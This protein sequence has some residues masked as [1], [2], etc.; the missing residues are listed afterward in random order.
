M[1][2]MKYGRT[3]KTSTPPDKSNGNES[4]KEVIVNPKERTY[5][6]TLYSGAEADEINKRA[7]KYES[8][9]KAY[10][11]AQEQYKADMER[12]EKAMKFYKS[13]PAP[14]KV[15][16]GVSINQ[17][18]KNAKGQK[19]SFEP[20]STRYSAEIANNDLKRAMK[21]NKN[22]VDINDPSINPTSRKIYMEQVAPN[23]SSRDMYGATT[24]KLYVDKEELNKIKSNR[25]IWGED[26]DDREWREATKK[27][28]DYFTQWVNKK[29]YSGRSFIPKIGTY[30]EYVTP[31]QAE[32]PKLRKP[33]ESEKVNRIK[34]SQINPKDLPKTLALTPKK[35]SELRV[36]P[37]KPK[38]LPDLKS[39]ELVEWE[40]PT[41]KGSKSAL[42]LDVSREGGQGG[43]WGLRKKIA[44]DGSGKLS[45]AVRF[46][47]ET[48]TYTRP[49]GL[50]YKREEKLA[51]AFYSP[52]NERGRGG[53]Y[54]KG[55]EGLVE[56]KGGSY[57]EYI[58]SRKQMKQELKGLRSERR[59][60]R[61]ESTASG[62][63][64]QAAMKDF[65]ED[66]KTARL[67]KA[68]ARKGRLAPESED[69]WKEGGKSKLKYFT[70]DT[71]KNLERGAM[72]NYVKA[73]ESHVG[74]A[75]DLRMASQRDMTNSL[76]TK[77]NKS[78]KYVSS[79]EEKTAEIPVI[80]AKAAQF[81]G[82]DKKINTENTLIN[83]QLAMLNP[84]IYNKKTKK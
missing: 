21:E 52:V 2:M 80:K 63:T 82:W 34:A 60:Y 81:K 49:K 8:D 14:T 56:A 6:E 27:G 59:D 9:L 41:P 36:T 20:I 61:K 10:N 78:R 64:K 45:P 83:S 46:N 22:I 48:Q 51:K 74:R 40:A 73:A 15:E 77:G 79:A 69:T 58:G 66:I 16:N 65:R 39:R 84:L 71:N 29:G 70:P 28:N 31:T 76:M 55:D 1:A 30:Q 50:R 43:K 24:G 38:T 7:D 54:A 26:F 25:D 12:Y 3:T 33:L 32:A 62:E 5:G 47:E 53:Y 72:Y 44:S 75:S 19:V 4:K 23:L 42:K 11:D 67:A 68:Y 57:Q 17:G 35:A 13:G 37:N 18:I